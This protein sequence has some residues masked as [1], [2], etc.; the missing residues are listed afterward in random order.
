M[1]SLCLLTWKL[2]HVFVRFTSIVI[3]VVVLYR[4]CL[5]KCKS[6]AFA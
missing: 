5:P 2:Q 4:L 1:P 6:S 3:G